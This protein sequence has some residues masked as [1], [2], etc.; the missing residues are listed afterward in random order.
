MVEITAISL[1]RNIFFQGTQIRSID[2]VCKLKIFNKLSIDNKDN[3]NYQIVNI[4]I[5]DFKV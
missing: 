4:H 3:I 1:L 5:I 2:Y